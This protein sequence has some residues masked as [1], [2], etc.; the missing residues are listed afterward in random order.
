VHDERFSILAVLSTERALA[1]RI[2]FNEILND[3]DDR[4]ARNVDI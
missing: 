1:E 2:D 4:K 3:F